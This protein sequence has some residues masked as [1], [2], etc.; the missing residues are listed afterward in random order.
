MHDDNPKLHYCR[1]NT[2]L[3]IHLNLGLGGNVLASGS[4]ARGFKSG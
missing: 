3:F 4:K 1:L 2:F